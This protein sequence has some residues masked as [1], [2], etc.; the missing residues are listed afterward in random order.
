MEVLCAVAITALALTALYRGLGGSQLAT[1]Q[2]E[3]HMGA[4]IVAKSILEDEL[5]SPDTAADQRNGTT[6]RYGWTL[7]IEP[8][9]VP[10]ADLPQGH[11]LYRL[12][13]QI[14]WQPRGSFVLNTLKLAK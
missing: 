6:G 12:T 2:L 8:T 9:S 14:T 5:S 11:R 1:G 3:A 13:A 4:R 7:T 10:G